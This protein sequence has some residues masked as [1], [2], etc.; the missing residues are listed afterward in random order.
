MGVLDRPGI[1]KTWPY[2]PSS[3]LG[4]SAGG[5]IMAWMDERHDKANSVL[6]VVSSRY[7][8]QPYSAL[9]RH[10]A[11][12]AAASKRPNFL[13]PVFVEP[14]EP[15]ALLAPLKRCDLHG[16]NEDGARARLAAF[17]MPAARPTGPVPFPGAPK[18]TAAVGTAPVAFP[19]GPRALSNIPISVSRPFLGR[20]EEL[21]AIHDHLMRA[22]RSAPVVAIYGPPG[23][24]KTTLA[25]AYAEQH[26]G[27]Y[28]A[29]WLIRAHSRKSDA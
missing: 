11:Q 1:I 8:D 4:D 13:L 9:E 27:D 2:S 15:P 25:A 14:C 24:G 28:R 21:V 17:M 5:N 22:G 29:T 3:R 12:W 23:T 19:G 16:L 7:L 18:A 26:R 10:G 20:D 6:C